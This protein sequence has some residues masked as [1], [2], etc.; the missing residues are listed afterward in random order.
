MLQNVNIEPQTW[1]DYVAR[2]KLWETDMRLIRVYKVRC[3]EDGTNQQ[4][5]IFLGILREV[6][7]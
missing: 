5:I 2:P 7:K 6:K 1:I 4:R 3:N